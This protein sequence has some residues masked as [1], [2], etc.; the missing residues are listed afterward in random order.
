MVLVFFFGSRLW[1]GKGFLVVVVVMDVG[2]K[3]RKR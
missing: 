1:K 2:W 3:M